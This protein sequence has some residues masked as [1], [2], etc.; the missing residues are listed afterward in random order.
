M[1]DKQHS[2]EQ[3]SLLHRPGIG[4][5][6]VSAG[7][8]LGIELPKE[9]ARA[10]ALAE[11]LCAAAQV[12]DELDPD[13]G[14]AIDVELRTLLGLEALPPEL[15]RHVRTFSR[16]RFEL[17]D[18]LTRLRLSDLV[19]KKALMRSVRAVLKA[20]SVY[21]DTERDY[22]AKLAHTLRISPTDID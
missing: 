8:H 7:G 17:V 15:A 3:A 1:A 9:L 6:L 18:T 12:D 4:E 13:E 11:V 5:R 21:R 14:E 10:Q 16:S 2:G 22:F 19:H 20:D